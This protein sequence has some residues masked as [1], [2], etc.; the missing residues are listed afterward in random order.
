ANAI[1]AMD[2]WTR[3]FAEVGKE[4]PQ[5]TTDHAYIDAACMWLVKNPEQFDTVVTNNIFGDILTDLGAVLQGGMGIAASGNIHPGR[6]SM[7]E[8]IHG[9]APK[10]KG[11]GVASPVAAI[12]AC[13]MMLEY[14]GETRAAAR[15]EQAI[16]ELLKTRKIPSLDSSSG[17]STSACGD[18]IARQ[19]SEVRL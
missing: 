6:V 14:L 11:K 4:Y 17:L 19:L 5:V 10:Y 18:L 13:G 7:F 16:A 1:R 2:I 3:T 8:P 12:A 15:I 9:S